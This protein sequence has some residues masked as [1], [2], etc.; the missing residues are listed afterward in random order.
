MSW[1]GNLPQTIGERLVQK[2]QSCSARSFTQTWQKTRKMDSW[3]WWLVWRMALCM[4]APLSFWLLPVWNDKRE[5]RF[6]WKIEGKSGKF[7]EYSSSFWCSYPFGLCVLIPNWSNNRTCILGASFILRIF[8][9]SRIWNQQLKLGET[10]NGETL[11]FETC[12]GIMCTGH[13]VCPIVVERPHEDT[14]GQRRP[15]R[16]PPTD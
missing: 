7:L 6:R 15:R 1:R 4:Q 13:P 14:E 9:T 3:K 10:C 16:W 2:P 5:N 12:Q 8:F 11:A